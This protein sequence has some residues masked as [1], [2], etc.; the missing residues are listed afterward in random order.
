VCPSKLLVLLRVE[1]CHGTL[2]SGVSYA[3]KVVA[4]IFDTIIV[5]LGYREA[6]T[7]DRRSCDVVRQHLSRIQSICAC[8]LLK[9][10]MA[11]GLFRALQ[12]NALLMGRTIKHAD[13]YRVSVL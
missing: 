8:Y 13:L 6:S 10:L 2:R 3:A 11:S 7:D 5:S 1:I 9:V 4:P 12:S